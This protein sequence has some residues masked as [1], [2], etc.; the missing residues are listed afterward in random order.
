MTDSSML[1]WLLDAITS[2]CL[3]VMMVAMAILAV[4]MVVVTFVCYA[5]MV[6][7]KIL[8]SDDDD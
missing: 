1:D 5:I 4:I 6:P 2:M 3:A 7:M 8:M